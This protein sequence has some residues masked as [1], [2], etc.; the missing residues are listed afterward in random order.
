MV[1]VMIGIIFRTMSGTL[2]FAAMSKPALGTSLSSVL[3]VQVG[4]SY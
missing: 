1:A 3:W 4:R 2:F